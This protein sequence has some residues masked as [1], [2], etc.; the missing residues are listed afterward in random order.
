MK[1]S[2][3]AKAGRLPNGVA[4][5]A[6]CPSWFPGRHYPPL[7]PPWPLVSAFKRGAVNEERYRREYILT[8]LSKL[9]PEKVFADL[10][11]DAILL[12]YE[13]AGEH[14]HRRIVA[15]WLADALGIDIDE[16]E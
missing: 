4:I 13:K 9:D 5:T 3:F 7:A 16:V 11:E 14:C 2:Y 10:G 12:C 8:V 15:E 6:Y 1:T